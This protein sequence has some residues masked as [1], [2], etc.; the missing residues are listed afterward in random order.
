MVTMES[1]YNVTDGSF[2]VVLHPFGVPP[3]DWSIETICLVPFEECFFLYL[4]VLI[5]GLLKPSSGVKNKRALETIA[6]REVPSYMGRE[7]TDIVL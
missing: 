3:R 5:G 7:C 4:R 2:D 1:V 6:E